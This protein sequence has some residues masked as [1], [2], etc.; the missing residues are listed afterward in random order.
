[1]KTQQILFFVICL[2][3]ATSC[4]RSSDQADTGQTNN[5]SAE[6]VT[7]ST[8]DGINSNE[9]TPVKLIDRIPGIWVIDQ[10]TKNGNVISMEEAGVPNQPL[11]FARDGRYRH[12][13]EKAKID[14]GS[15][16]I[17]ERQES[18]YFESDD[19][20]KVT[21]WNVSFDEDNRMVMSK[22]DSNSKEN[23]KYFYRKKEAP[24]E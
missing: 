11:E 4:N 23:L 7:K 12:Y 8:N 3:S 1:M 21:E 24:L 9:P 18:L 17:N 22:A 20:K 19:Q 2:I 13:T 15:Y 16:R 6:G 5:D 10:V 14:S